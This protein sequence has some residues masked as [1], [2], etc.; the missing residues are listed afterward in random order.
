MVQE[1]RIRRQR[2]IHREDEREKEIVEPRAGLRARDMK[3]RCI[4]YTGTCYWPFEPARRKSTK[5][6]KMLERYDAVFVQCLDSLCGSA[7]C[8]RWLGGHLMVD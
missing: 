6:S 2:L 7:V 3:R 5:S 4:W 8:E 1:E